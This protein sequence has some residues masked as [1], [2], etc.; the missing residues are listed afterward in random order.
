MKPHLQLQITSIWVE[1][2]F[3]YLMIKLK[4]KIIFQILN[5]QLFIFLRTKNIIY[6]YKSILEKNTKFPNSSFTLFFNL[7]FFSPQLSFPFFV[8]PFC[9]P[10]T[11][12]VSNQTETRTKNTKKLH[13]LHS[14][15]Q[16]FLK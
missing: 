15:L 6:L 10:D 4:K 8:F 16:Y 3:S 13:S 14:K 2:L 1:S 11:P 9:L 5:Y 12:K 7:L